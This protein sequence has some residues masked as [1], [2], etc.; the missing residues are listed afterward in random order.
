MSR[1]FNASSNSPVFLD[2]SPAPE[3]FASP[4]SAVL[5][6]LFTGSNLIAV[7]AQ[8]TKYWGNDLNFSLPFCL[9]DKSSIVCVDCI[10]D[11]TWTHLGSIHRKPCYVSTYTV[12]RTMCTRFSS[13]LHNAKK[14]T[15]EQILGMKLTLLQDCACLYKP[16]DKN[17]DTL[18]SGCHAGFRPLGI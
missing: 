13:P 8:P 7:W 10:A 16:H 4:P 1:D 15:W 18:Y 12:W 11:N 14:K 6:I 5:T 9:F 2:T 3:S 17:L